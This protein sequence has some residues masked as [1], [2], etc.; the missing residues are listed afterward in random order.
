MYKSGRWL[1]DDC[2]KELIAAIEQYASKGNIL[3]LGCGTA[4]IVSY[5]NQDKFEYLL[6]VDLSPV[7][8]AKSRDRCGNYKIH[9]QVGDMLE[10]RCERKYDV[11]LFSESLYCVTATQ[12][13]SLLKK[14]SQNLSVGGRIIVTL[15]DAKRYMNII[16]MIRDV[17]VV[18]KEEKMEGTERY[19]MVFC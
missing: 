16:E 17:F 14:L 5:L 15:Y 2:S 1:F 4:S 6:G 3:I 9:F 10:Y 8:I 13:E 18:T 19:L 12:R 7:A 11:I